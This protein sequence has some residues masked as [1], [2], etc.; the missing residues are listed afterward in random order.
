MS[1]EATSALTNNDLILA[2][3]KKMGLAY[4]GAAGTSPAAVPIDTHDLA[5]AQEIVNSGIRMFIT[6]APP[7]GWKWMQPV[8][9]VAL[10]A[11]IGLDT[12]TISAGAYDSVNDQTLLTATVATFQESMEE[13]TITITGDGNPVIKTYVSATQVYVYGDSHT[14]SAKTFT[15]IADGDYTL[16]RTFAG[17]YNGEITFAAATNRAVQLQWTGEATVREL[18]E[19]VTVQT[20]I[21]R[22]VALDQFIPTTGRRRWRLRS[23]PIP[24]QLFN[25]QFPFDLSF[26]ALVS[27][28]LTDNP[29]TPLVHDE[30]VR[31]ACLA[32]VERDVEDSPDG[33]LT[34]YYQRALENARQID[35]RS[36]PRRLGYFG[37][38][39]TVV[40]PRNFREYMKR[41]NVIFNTP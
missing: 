2:V 6:D 18:R 37:N 7:G 36:G 31:A 13:K 38:D 10:W 15:I 17:S 24:Y 12:R 16:P 5:L 1:T 26:N 8:Q 29:P 39:R 25:V 33:P 4:Y 20:G 23:Y 3:S 35:A 21:P 11:T 40:T 27:T 14:V 32:V 9:Q 22:Y 30:A 28:S 19:N 41:P 34:Q